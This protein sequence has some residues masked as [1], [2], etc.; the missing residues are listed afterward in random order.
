MEDQRGRTVQLYFCHWSSSLAQ[1]LIVEIFIEPLVVNTLSSQDNFCLTLGV[2][3]GFCSTPHVSGILL[4]LWG[5]MSIYP[6]TFYESIGLGKG[7]MKKRNQV[8][9]LNISP[10]CVNRIFSVSKNAVFIFKRLLR[11]WA[12]KN[13]ICLNIITNICFYWW[14][15]N[16][17]F[18]VKRKKYVWGGQN[19]F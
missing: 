14:Y 15:Q 4:T 3:L 8:G 1:L 9:K 16:V 12:Q 13:G 7:K 6:V 19:T 10:S 11:N 17:G 18:T 5:Y 2:D